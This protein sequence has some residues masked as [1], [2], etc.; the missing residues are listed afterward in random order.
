MNSVNLGKSDNDILLHGSEGTVDEGR[1]LASVF[2]IFPFFL[3]R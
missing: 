1:R 3:L 2:D